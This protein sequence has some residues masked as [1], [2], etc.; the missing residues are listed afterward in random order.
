MGSAT[1]ALFH[2]FFEDDFPLGAAV[3]RALIVH[4]LSEQHVSRSAGGAPKPI[5]HVQ[6]S[7]HPNLVPDSLVYREWAKPKSGGRA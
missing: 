1:K 6:G 7:Y 5:G 3:G 4:G 2:L